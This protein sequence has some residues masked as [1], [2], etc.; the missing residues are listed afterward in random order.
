MLVRV[1]TITFILVLI[2]SVHT[3]SEREKVYVSSRQYFEV[4]QSMYVSLLHYAA[5][6]SVNLWT[7]SKAFF[8]LSSK[9]WVESTPRGKETWVGPYRFS[10]AT[11]PFRTPRL[12]LGCPSS[13]HARASRAN[14]P[15]CNHRGITISLCGQC[16]TKP[17][18][19]HSNERKGNAEMAIVC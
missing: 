6:L 9:G 2:G 14:I 7:S 15:D 3:R 16:E 5:H 8:S 18:Y 1:F 12:G 10:Y 19:T 17:Q 4:V 13:N 11:V